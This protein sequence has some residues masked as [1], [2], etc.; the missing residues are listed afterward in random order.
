MEIYCRLSEEHLA[1]LGLKRHYGSYDGSQG[2]LCNI[3]ISQGII[4]SM[5]SHIGKRF[6]QILGVYDQR[7][8]II[9][10][11]KDDGH[12]IRLGIIEP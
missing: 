6:L 2:L 3:S 11:L 8:L 7:P 4:R 10:D 5:F 1:A 9:H 12:D